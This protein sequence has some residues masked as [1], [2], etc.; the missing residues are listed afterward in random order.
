MKAVFTYNDGNNK[1]IKE[2]E[3]DFLIP[4]D[5]GL[6]LTLEEG[7]EVYGIELAE[8]SIDLTKAPLVVNYNCFLK[9]PRKPMGYISVF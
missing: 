7:V 9:K 5:S 2:L 1:V 3:I 6:T 8:K 4:N